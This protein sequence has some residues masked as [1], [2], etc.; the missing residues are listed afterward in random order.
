M[1]DARAAGGPAPRRL[2]VY[3]GGFLTQARIRRVLSLAGYDIRLG[4]PRPEDAVGVWGKSPTAPRGER[5]ADHLGRDV[6]RVEDA[7]L[8]S[9]RTGREGAAPLGLLIDASGVHFDASVPSDLEKLLA[10]H[11]LDDTAL[12][13]RAR[14]GMARLRAAH[15]S[16]YNAC[17]PTLPAPPPGYVLVIDQTKGDASITYGG[18]RASTFREMLF[19]AQE[20]H[21]GAR[22]IIRTHPEAEAGGRPG[23]FGPED[24]TGRISLCGAMTSPHHL[25]EGA[26][27]V[28]TVSSQL[29]FEAIL[30]GHKPRLFGQPF[31]AGW[32][33]SDDEN[34][35]WRRQRKLT[36]AQL[37]AAAMLLYPTWFDPCRDRLCPFEDVLDQLEAEVRAFRD[38]LA[39]HVAVGMRLWKRPHLQRFF[40]R[41]RPLR[42]ANSLPLAETLA[43]REGRG[44]LVWGAEGQGTGD[45]PLAHVEDGFLRSRGLGA[46]LVP[47]LSLIADR[48]GIYYDPSRE[49]DL[50]AL[51]AAP[52]PPGGEARA[53][54]LIRSLTQAGLSKYN[55]PATALPPLPDGR[56]LL[57]PGQ[58]EDD[59]SVRFGAGE[60]RTNLA[61]LAAVR[62]ANPCAIL[63][64][65]PHPDVQAGLRPG[66][67][68]EEDART[69]ADVILDGADAA[70]AIDSADE[71]WTITSTLGFEALMRGK[72]VTCLGM[73][74]YA[75]WGLTRDLGRPAPDRRVARPTLAALAHACL[76]AYPRYVDPLT[77][78]PCP[79]EVIVERLTQ[80][81]LP[82]SGPTLRLLSKLQGL[83]ASQ[84]HL[85]R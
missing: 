49:S 19:V 66:R 29:G 63:I 67:V 78:L 22:I 54:R 1:A 31:Y 7:F 14:V 72:P 45:L 32:G 85:W 71:V 79:P 27:A 8:R 20:E 76:I 84:A 74:F 26:V 37:F 55:L 35:V 18:A 16:K 61:L 52:P 2:F 51:I 21:P 53:E 46:E 28:Y 73:P 15:L 36:R 44:L 30:A 25:L 43:R 47:P 58:V 59:A 9:V 50:E 24:A 4:A 81:H 68:T 57:V 83:F 23:H 41:E 70:T 65:K 62:A 5:V 82:K 6:V 12:L 39:G 34:P 48:R 64:W 17:D 11:P 77:G 60:V 40:G 13:D 80:G 42:F 33:L 3:N 38:D 69:I 75:G 10:S 56:R